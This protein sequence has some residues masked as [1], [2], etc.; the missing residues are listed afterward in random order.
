MLQNRHKR[1]PFE[2]IGK[3]IV[4]NVSFRIRIVRHTS[5]QCSPLSC[6]P[7]LLCV[8]FPN[9]RKTCKGNNMRSSQRRSFSAI[10]FNFRFF[11]W[12]V[13]RLLPLTEH[14]VV[15]A[16]Q[17]KLD[18]NVCRAVNGLADETIGE[19]L[20]RVCTN[21]VQRADEQTTHTHTKISHTH[22][23]CQHVNRLAF[24]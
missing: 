6:A 12:F 20:I 22:I 8:N 1:L 19:M 24:K 2:I 3:Y 5:V 23:Q 18:D 7:V 14:I 11:W 4:D 9:R 16:A 17:H 10:R 15:R 13:E 21:F